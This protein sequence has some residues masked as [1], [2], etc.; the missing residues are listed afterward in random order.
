MYYCRQG[1]SGKEPGR[2]VHMVRHD[3]PC[4]EPIA[5]LIKVPQGVGHFVGDGGV[6]QVTSARAAVEEALNRWSREALDSRAFIGAEVT[7]KTDGSL[8]DR[9][10]LGF[11]AIKN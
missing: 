2:D 5:L 6:L 4:K 10:S 7:S 9:L 11:D 3:A 1:L 8:D